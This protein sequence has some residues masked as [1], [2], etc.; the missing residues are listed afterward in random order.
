MDLCMA[1]LLSQLSP[2]ASPALDPLLSGGELTSEDFLAILPTDPSIHVSQGAE[3]KKE[4]CAG[5]EEGLYQLYTTVKSTLAGFE[6][7]V[8]TA[9]DTHSTP[10]LWFYACG[11]S[12]N[13]CNLMLEYLWDSALSVLPTPNEWKKSHNAAA[14]LS[15]ILARGNYVSFE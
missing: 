15:G 5:E 10:Y 3:V 6:E 14:F 4:E 7:H 2:T 1:V 11:L 8:L 9:H 12:P 13:I